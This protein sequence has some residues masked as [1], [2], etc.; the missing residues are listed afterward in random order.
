M[1]AVNNYDFTLYSGAFAAGKTI[2]LCIVF[3]TKALTYPKSRW[4]I[5]C[6]TY[7]MLRDTIIHT[8]F[9][10][11]DLYQQKLQEQHIPIELTRSWNKTENTW[12][13]Y[14]ES[15]ILFRSCEEPSKLKSLNLDGFGLDE[16]V[17]IDEEI[18]KMLQ[19]RLR[20][21]HTDH[22]FGFLTGNPAGYTNWV[23][24]HFFIRKLP[25]YT[26][27]E[28]NT[29]DNVYLPPGYIANLERSL[30]EDYANRYLRGCWGDFEGLVYKDFHKQQ[31]TGDYTRKSF[32]YYI[33]GYDDGYRN[34]ACL[35]ILGVTG[36]DELY[37]IHEYYMSG[38]TNDEIAEDITRLYQRY[39]FYK[40]YCD[41]SGLNAIETFKR[42]GLNAVSADN[43]KK[44]M[45]SGISKLKSLFKQNKIFIDTQC[46][47]LVW[48]LE[49]YRYEK[50][51]KTGNYNEEPVKKDDHACD[52]LRYALTDYLPGNEMIT[53]YYGR[54][55]QAFDTILQDNQDGIRGFIK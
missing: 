9:E 10:E 16:P 47:K 11:L 3:T 38:R 41:P 24:Q 37:V 51:K 31:H 34:P 17:D 21:T 35:L 13:G 23:Y 33:A 55:P 46:S 1:K 15:E 45:N 39:P 54:H 53:A 20:G 6:Q 5:G 8:F 48:E 44:T 30:D 14:N 7:P 49:S 25:N 26:V 40:I 18:F 12:T 50:D 22:R 32:K 52:A 43:D 27:I 4:L 36:D 29:Y 28:T 42:H 19:G 2:L